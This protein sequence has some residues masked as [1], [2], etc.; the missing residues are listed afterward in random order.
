MS[1]CLICN[2]I[3]ENLRTVQV[4]LHIMDILRTLYVVLHQ[5]LT[6]IFVLT[7]ENT[8]SDLKVDAL[9]YANELLV[10][11]RLFFQRLLQTRLY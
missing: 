11:V 8:D 9:H 1:D 10:R 4:V 3:R 6:E 2:D 7:I 5:V